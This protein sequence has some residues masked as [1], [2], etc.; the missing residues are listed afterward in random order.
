LTP[1][2]LPATL[3]DWLDEL[4]R[5]HPPHVMELGLDRPLRAMRRLGIEQPDPTHTR[6]VTIAGTNGKGSVAMLLARLLQRTGVS[7]GLY[8]SPHLY[9]FR[10][11]VQVNGAMLDGEDW[12]RA[13]N[14]IDA[15]CRDLQLT[16]FE[17][18][19]LA[20]FLLLGERRLRVWILEIGLGGRLDVVNC[21]DNQLNLITS[22]GLDHTD[23]LGDNLESIA[24]EKAGVMRA[25][26]TTI[27]GSPLGVFTR[28]AQQAGAALQQVDRD[29]RVEERNHAIRVA[30]SDWKVHAPLPGGVLAANLA[31]ALLAAHELNIPEVETGL[32]SLDWLAEETL[33]GRQQLVHWGGMRCL[34]DVSHNRDGVAC[35]AHR[36]ARDFANTPMAAVFACLEDKQ[37]PPDLMRLFPNVH[38]WLVGELQGVRT[39]SAEAVIERAGLHGAGRLTDYSA[40]ELRQLV[41]DGLL[42]VFGSFLLPALVKS[43]LVSEE[44]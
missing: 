18:V 11:R 23:R 30:S 21:L 35:L 5:R 15:A 19:T 31:M 22:I 7:T 9:D 20:A 25:Q 8:L 44:K 2:T 32:E 12:V 37:P 6:I 34:L 43:L 42:L 39:Q 13:F 33:P 28:L 41:G 10:E 16:F 26:T 4:A 38:T 1:E 14:R 27:C 17:W 36:V 3:A 40:R 24:A 29:W